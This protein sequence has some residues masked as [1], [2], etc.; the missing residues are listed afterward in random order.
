MKTIPKQNPKNLP[1]SYGYIITV[2][3]EPNSADRGPITA[4]DENGDYERAIPGETSM[5]VYP[6]KQDAED[7]IKRATGDTDPAIY[8]GMR[9]SSLKHTRN[10]IAHQC[11]AYGWVT[12]P[13][14]KPKRTD[15][16]SHD[17]TNA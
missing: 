11:A 1:A 12:Y 4:I 8:D 9:V 3:R 15:Y 13:V 10:M 6:S 16:D 2:S 17:F 14:Y 7:A 5:A